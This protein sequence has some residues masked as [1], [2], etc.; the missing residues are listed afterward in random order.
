MRLGEGAV[1]VFAIALG[2]CGGAKN[3]RPDEMS[4]EAHRSESSRE[5]ASAAHDA[6]QYDPHARV[7]HAVI[8]GAVGGVAE[9][10]E[11]VTTYNPTAF[12]LTDAARHAKH[13]RQHEAAATELEHFEGAECGALS[14]RVRAACPML[15]P[16][17]RLQEI[18][19]GVRIEFVDGADVGMLTAQMRCHLAFARARAFAGVPDCPLY[20]KGIEIQAS[21]DRRGIDFTTTDRATATEIRRRAN[22]LQVTR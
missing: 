19:G 20:I 5:N 7:E 13:A 9:P 4:A 12:H 3:V 21:P 15:A 8:H 17:K 2:A 1:V 10:V 18:P 14:P 11:S 16:I 6:S 22:D